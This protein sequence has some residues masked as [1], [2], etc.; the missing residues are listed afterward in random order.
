MKYIKTHVFNFILEFYKYVII[1]IDIFDYIIYAC[2]NIDD[3]INLIDKLIFSRN[4]NFYNIV[5]N[6]QFIIIIDICDK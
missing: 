5:Y 3:E 6:I 4:I 1:K 2:L